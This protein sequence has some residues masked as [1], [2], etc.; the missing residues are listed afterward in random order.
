[1]TFSSPVRYRMIYDNRVMYSDVIPVLVVVLNLILE[2][3]QFVTNVLYPDPTEH[4]PSFFA[5]FTALNQ[6]NH[7]LTVLVTIIILLAFQVSCAWAVLNCIAKLVTT[8]YFIN[9]TKQ[10]KNKQTKT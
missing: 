10:N 8:Y 5:T 6:I 4:T 2:C 7:D 1:M 3:E 9:K